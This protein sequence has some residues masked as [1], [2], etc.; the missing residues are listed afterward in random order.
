MLKPDYD[1]YFSVLAPTHTQ[2]PSKLPVARRWRSL[3]RTQS[4]P[5]TK[6]HPKPLQW[7]KNTRTTTEPCTPFAVICAF[8][9]NARPT[10]THT[11]I[12]SLLLSNTEDKAKICISLI[13]ILC[14]VHHDFRPFSDKLSNHFV[15]VLQLKH[16]DSWAT[17]SMCTQIRARARAL[18]CTRTFGAPAEPNEWESCSHLSDYSTK[19]MDN[20]LKSFL[21]WPH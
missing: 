11:H 20:D 7:M 2:T 6:S 4:I 9:A 16:R 10:H 13:C 12:C 21:C 3:V 8:D 14:V 19:W 15:F 1:A 5:Q 17:A 18:A